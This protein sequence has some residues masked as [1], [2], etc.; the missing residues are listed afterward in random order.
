VFPLITGAG[1]V[2]LTYQSKLGAD[3]RESVD[4]K[5][6]VFSRLDNRFLANLVKVLRPILQRLIN[7]KLTKGVRTVNRMTE[8]LVTQ[9]EQV[10]R[11]MKMLTTD[12]TEAQAFRAVLLAGVKKPR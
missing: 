5:V 4:T 3:G 12:E 1:V 7:N 11:D 2:M 10:V 6:T 8:Y 9:P